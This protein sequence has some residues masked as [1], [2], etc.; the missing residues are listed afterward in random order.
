MAGPVSCIWTG[1]HF[2]PET[3]AQHR[4]ASARFGVG[5]VVPLDVAHPRSKV[6]HDHFFAV[7]TE[8]HGT[9]PESLAE[10]FPTPDSLR[11]YALCKAGYCDVETFVGSSM[12]EA[13]RIAAFMRA[14]VRDGVQVVVSGRSVTRLT[15]HSQSLRAM[16][17]KVFQESKS[18]V[19]EV[20]ADLL[21]TTPDRLAVAA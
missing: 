17:G 13:V 1:Q 19:L 9:L 6:S 5:E 2:A 20:I 8:A 14:G 21:E 10:R 7:V 4:A 3:P 11:H 16:G 18:A 12:A 15:P